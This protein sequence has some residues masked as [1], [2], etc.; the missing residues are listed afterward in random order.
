MALNFI[1]DG[2]GDA[3]LEN[4]D[5]FQGLDKESAIKMIQESEGI[6]S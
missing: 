4:I 2:D 6:L 1:E 5:K 3:V